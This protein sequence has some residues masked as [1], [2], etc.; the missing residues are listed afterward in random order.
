[1]SQT[2]ITGGDL[3]RRLIG[4]LL[5]VL[6]TLLLGACAGHGGSAQAPITPASQTQVQQP[7]QSS[8][9]QSSPAQT[10]SAVQQV[11][12][13]DQQVQ[14]TLPDLDNAQNAA[15]TSDNGQDDASLP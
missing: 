10:G 9:G 7:A 13:L 6:L 2:S 11:Q 3:K 5:I 8:G 12:N 4:A 15:N 14:S 1:V